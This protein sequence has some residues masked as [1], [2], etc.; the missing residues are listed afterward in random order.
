M[1]EVRRQHILKAW[2]AEQGRRYER[3]ANGNDAMAIYSEDLHEW[4]V[5][6]YRALDSATTAAWTRMEFQKVEEADG[7]EVRSVFK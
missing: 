1:L 2:C 7:M 5:S 3:V 6:K 4:L